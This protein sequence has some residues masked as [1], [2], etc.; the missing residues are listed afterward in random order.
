MLCL[1]A[2]SYSTRCNPMDCSLPG[3]S[4]RGILQ[5]QILE[6]FAIS[7]SRHLPNPGIEP[8]FPTMQVDP[9]LSE[10]PGKPGALV[11]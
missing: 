9:L 1:V 4:V 7:F 3:S 11:Y 5:A 8:R 2:Q 6:W 10:P